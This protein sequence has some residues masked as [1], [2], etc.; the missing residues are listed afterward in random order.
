MIKQVWGPLPLELCPP[1]PAALLWPES[2]LE[3]EWVSRAF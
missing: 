2:V 3:A 1:R